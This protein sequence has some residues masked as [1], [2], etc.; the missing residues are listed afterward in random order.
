MDDIIADK[1][2][3]LAALEEAGI[4][5][6]PH[7]YDVTHQAKTVLEE[8]K[9]VTSTPSEE[10]VS[11]AGRVMFS[12]DMGKLAFLKVQDDSGQIQVL[13]SKNDT[14]EFS[15][16]KNLDVGD[17]VGVAGPVFRTKTDEITVRAHQLTLLSKNLMPMP[18]KYH[19]IQDV[20]IR[21]RKRYLDLLYNPESKDRFV[22]RSKVISGIRKFLDKQGFLE[23]ETPILQPIYGGANARPFVTHHNALK[24]DLYLRISNELYL[25]RLVIGGFEKIYEIAR[26]FRNE[27][28]DTTHNPEFTQV[29]WYQA[30]ADYTVMM[31]QAE[32]LISGLAQQLHG[33]PKVVVGTETISLKLPFTRLRMVDAIKKYA[34]L[35]VED[36]D[37]QEILAY[38]KKHKATPN[39]P[40]WGYA[41]LALFEELVEEQLIQPTFITDY[42]VETSPLTKIH[43]KDERYV[44]RFEL[45]INGWEIANAY[46][47]L[48]DPRDQ[49]A[50]LRQQVDERVAGDDEAHPMDEDFVEA[51]KYGMP[52][53]GGIGIGI[54]RLVMLLTNTT[55]IRDVIFFPAMKPKQ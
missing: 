47:E 13:L 12:R 29:E 38:C 25:K 45:F 10:I 26:D 19:G 30:Y 35:N 15:L 52:P 42:P 8:F 28:V 54:D 23:V 39:Q 2:D 21:Y 31:Q 16:L 11:V 17:I 7:R 46:S 6:Y 18:E 4:T 27:G 49:E 24:Q 43:R 51:M 5:A 32:Q 14:K 40:T 41:V 1:H 34:N 44:E 36:M 55:S 9:N 33:E 3:K 53:T 22:K 37:E 48:T 50:R 20:E